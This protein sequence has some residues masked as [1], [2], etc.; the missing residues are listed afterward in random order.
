MLSTE[1]A[2]PGS[3]DEAV[4][5]RI[6]NTVTFTGLHMNYAFVQKEDASLMLDMKLEPLISLL[7]TTK[8]NHSPT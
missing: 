6:P 7:S 2:L 1:V 4:Y 8:F 5:A 3:S